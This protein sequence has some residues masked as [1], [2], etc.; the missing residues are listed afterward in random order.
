MAAGFKQATVNASSVPSTQTNFPSYVDLS[1]LGITT[2]AEAR[3]VRVYADSAKT[4]E[5]A[6]E[7][8]SATEMHVKI[9]SLTSS[10][11]IYVD[12]D[13]ISSDYAATDTYGRNAVWSD[14]QFVLHMEGNATDSTG[15]STP[16]ATS[17]T[18][19]TTAGRLG[20]RGGSFNGT[21]SRIVL[22]SFSFGT[23][24]TIQYW[25]YKNTT[26]TSLISPW[27]KDNGTTRVATSIIYSGTSQDAY[28]WNTSAAIYVNSDTI[29]NLTWHKK[30]HT[31]LGGSYWRSF[32]DGSQSATTAAPLNPLATSFGLWIGA[33]QYAGG[34]W[35][36]NGYI[37]EFRQRKLFV[38]NDWETTEY[39]N[40]SAESTFWGTWTTVSSAP[41]NNGLFFG[42]GM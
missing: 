27:S 9:P 6:R 42:A 23:E 39:N 32:K 19:N 14:Y 25:M 18:Y 10:T 28:A 24:Y 31:Y 2:L 41:A 16:T 34:R 11:T 12:W 36:W 7:I 8:V 15:N 4:T 20:G 37:D 38:S 21:S 26:G 29:S 13:G 22:P 1:R 17:M 5:W 35:Y 3:S 40:Q 30:T 33:D